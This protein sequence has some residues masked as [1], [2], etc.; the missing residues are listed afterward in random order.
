MNFSATDIRLM[1]LNLAGFTASLILGSLFLYGSGKYTDHADSNL[2]AARN[3][4]NDAR[5]RLS[6]A[7][8]ARE[9]LDSYARDY[10][11]LE[12]RRIVG[13]E[14]RLDWMEGLDRLRGQNLVVDF[15]YTIAPQKAYTPQPAIDSGN[16]DKRYSEMKLKLD[17]L[18][19][20][21]LLNFFNALNKQIKGYYQ[22]DGCTMKRS[23]IG[24]D[25]DEQQPAS[26]VNLV[27]DCIGGWITLKNRNAR[28]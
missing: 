3:Q 20:G 2:R 8:H 24:S 26:G 14:Q 11:A 4:L 15:S 6:A 18:H 5:N 21:Q 17:L 12:Q 28:P 13:D 22:L 1:R 23:S 16:F 10:D 19:E 9:Y 25:G 7:Q 27:A